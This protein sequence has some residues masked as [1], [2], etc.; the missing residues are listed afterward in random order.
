MKNKF[1]YLILACIASFSFVNANDNQVMEEC[2]CDWGVYDE[3]RY[4]SVGVGPLIF[5]PNVGIGY[6]ERQAEWGWD[7]ALSFSTIGYAHQLSG[8]FVGHYYLNRSDFNSAYVG[9]GL[10]GSAIL[11]NHKGWVGTLSPD[12]VFGK[13]LEGNDACRHFIEMHV[14]IPTLCVGKHTRGFYLPLTYVKYGIS[15]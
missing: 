13:E 14:A 7:T 12:F 11:T 3:Y 10:M 2:D 15:F 1:A 6:R 4:A 5:I 8:H 9:F